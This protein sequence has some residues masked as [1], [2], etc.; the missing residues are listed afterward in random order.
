MACEWG[1]DHRIWLARSGMDEF[2]AIFVVSNDD[3]YMTNPATFG[4]GARK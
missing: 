2:D 3:A 4:V 1:N